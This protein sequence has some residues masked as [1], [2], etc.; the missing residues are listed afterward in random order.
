MKRVV[1]VGGGAA[2]IAA[3]MKAA[4]KGHKVTLL[5]AKSKLGGRLGSYSDQRSGFSF[6]LGVHLIT[7]GYSNTLKLLEMINASE[8]VEIQE[9]IRIPFYHPQQGKI[10]YKAHRIVPPFYFFN[11]I[12][13]FKLLS[14]SE[15]LRLLKRLIILAKKEHIPAVTAGEWLKDAGKA[16]YEYFWKPL[17]VSAMNCLPEE[18]DLNTLRTVLT[19]GFMQRGGLGFFKRL[20]SEVFDTKV[21]TALERAGV[22]IRLKFPVNEVLREGVRI[23]SVV[24]KTGEEVKGEAF[25][26]A[27]PPDSLIRIL[28]DSAE[29]KQQ[30][31]KFRYSTIINTHLVFAQPV[32][33]EDFGCLLE[34]LPQW[35]FRIRHDGDSAEGFSYSLV[36]SAADRLA[37]ADCD[38]LAKCLEDLGK[39]GGYIKGNKLLYSKIVKMRR[40]TIIV[41]PDTAGNR[42]KANTE[43][44]NLYLAGDWINTV[45]PATIESAVLSG[46]K[47][48][49]RV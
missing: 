25:I 32:F 45:L 17:I 4:Q 34:S 5:E 33:D 44:E 11:G 42:P 18:A 39:C 12:L 30:I 35:F 26:L 6:D 29:L 14:L 2:G 41:N 49:E 43:F 22:E 20:E 13:N 7:A 9:G 36:I 37:L 46:F 27:L 16:E 19:K 15:R 31:R 38:I 47:A 10:V 40:A 24:G 3:A 8:A 1:V 48:G 28:P 23:V 21:K